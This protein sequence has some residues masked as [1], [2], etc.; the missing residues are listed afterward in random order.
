MLLNTLNVLG[1]NSAEAEF[2]VSLIDT[3]LHTIAIL[4]ELKRNPGMS[5]TNAASHYINEVNHLYGLDPKTTRYIELYEGREDP[6][7]IRP[8]FENDWCQSVSFSPVDDS[9]R[10]FVLSNLKAE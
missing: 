10:E 2:G 6:C 4:I 9:L 8:R 1:P 3:D 5:V 7:L